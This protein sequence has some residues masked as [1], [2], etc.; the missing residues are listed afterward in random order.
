MSSCFDLLFF[1]YYYY[2]YK[3]TVSSAED[4]LYFMDPFL[5]SIFGLTNTKLENKK[6]TGRLSDSDVNFAHRKIFPHGLGLG[7]SLFKSEDG[8]VI[9][10][11]RDF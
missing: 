4:A 7:F 1:R 6:H 2:F 11:L 3:N 9:D 5:L 8:Q 10:T